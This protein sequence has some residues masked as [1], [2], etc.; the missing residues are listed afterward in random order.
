MKIKYK[1]NKLFSLPS[2]FWNQ[3][4]HSDFQKY[5][6]TITRK[7][8]GK[9]E[10]TIHLLSSKRWISFDSYKKRRTAV[11]GTNHITKACKQWTMKKKIAAYKQ[12]CTPQWKQ[13]KKSLETT[14]TSDKGQA[15]WGHR[16]WRRCGHLTCARNL[17]QQSPQEQGHLL[18]VTA[19]WC[20]CLSVSLID[21]L[22][23]ILVFPRISLST[24]WTTSK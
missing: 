2:T 24:T 11:Y 22:S 16:T 14:S 3:L 17:N 12:F 5:N 7:W 9:Q 15:L 6:L 18:F 23:R 13:T 4:S 20:V 10:Q 8:R 19:C 21:G 1:A